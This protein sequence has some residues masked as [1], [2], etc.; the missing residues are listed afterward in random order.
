MNT[1]GD[2]LQ[3]PLFVAAPSQRDVFCLSPPDKGE[4][5]LPKAVQGLMQC[6]ETDHKILKGS[7]LL[8]SLI[9]RE[10]GRSPFTTVR[11]ANLSKQSLSADGM[12]LARQNIKRTATH[13][14]EEK[15]GFLST[16]QFGFQT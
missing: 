10:Q 1:V 15:F 7:S 13:E 16:F 6:K 8:L 11:R 4:Y 5:G 14:Q 9:Q 12:L 2:K 3:C